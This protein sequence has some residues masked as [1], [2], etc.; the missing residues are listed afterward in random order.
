MVADFSLVIILIIIIILVIIIVIT[1]IIKK[2]KNERAKE[3]Q[4]LKSFSQLASFPC[5]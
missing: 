5:S 4:A 3:A 1:I 2:Y